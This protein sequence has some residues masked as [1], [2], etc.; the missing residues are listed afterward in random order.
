MLELL[1]NELHLLE[2]RTQGGNRATDNEK[3]RIAWL[4]ENIAARRISLARAR[5][6]EEEKRETHGGASTQQA[7]P[8][9]EPNEPVKLRSPRPK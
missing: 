7:I 8:A 3:T 6:E 4:K 5:E 9:T 2:V 1:I